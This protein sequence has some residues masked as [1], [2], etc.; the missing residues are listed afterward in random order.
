MAFTELN[1]FAPEVL[2]GQVALLGTR[3]T[4]GVRFSPTAGN[5]NDTL[6]AGDAVIFQTGKSSIPL[7]RAAAEDADADIVGLVAVGQ[8]RDTHKAGDMLEINLSGTV[9]HLTT[10]DDIS[11]GDEFGNIGISLDDASAGEF[12]RV[13]IKGVI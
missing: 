1:A 13:S 8:N 7:V 11:R 2:Q 3:R 12:T 5:A 9:V 4:L 10:A 6:K